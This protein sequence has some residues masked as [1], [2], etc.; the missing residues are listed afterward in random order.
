MGNDKELVRE[1]MSIASSIYESAPSG[2]GVTLADLLEASQRVIEIATEIEAN[3]D[4]R[5]AA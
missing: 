1:L 5:N 2:V 3:I 4:E